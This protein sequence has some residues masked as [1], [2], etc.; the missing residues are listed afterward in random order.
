VHSEKVTSNSGTIKMESEN[1]MEGEIS[2]AS[3]FINLLV[4]PIA[5]VI[6]KTS[7]CR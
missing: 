4:P 6:E 3:P 5:P 7:S 2:Q 1:Y